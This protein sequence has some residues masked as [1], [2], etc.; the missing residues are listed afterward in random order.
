MSNVGGST[1]SASGPRVIL[2]AIDE[3]PVR[4]WHM[5][6]VAEKEG[7]Q[8]HLRLLQGSERALDFTIENV[9]RAG[10]ANH[11]LSLCVSLGTPNRHGMVWEVSVCWVSA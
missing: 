7:S 5:R 9:L 3:S 1:Q 2:V 10:E 11:E 4:A 8:T 6:C